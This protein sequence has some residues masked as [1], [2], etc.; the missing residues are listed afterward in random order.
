VQVI[1]SGAAKQ[2]LEAFVAF[3]QKLKK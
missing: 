2:K 3:S 1:K